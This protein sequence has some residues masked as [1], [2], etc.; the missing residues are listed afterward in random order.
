MLMR[1]RPLINRNL[2]RGIGFVA[3]MTLAAAAYLWPDSR[4]TT[5]NAL[6]AQRASVTG[7]EK[8]ED[9]FSVSGKA[10]PVASSGERS[11]SA[12][13]DYK[14]SFAESH[15]YWEYA[16]QILPAAK[17]GNADA[18][19]YLSRLL[20]RC[21][22]ENTMYFQHKG[23]IL[24]L[25]E[26]LQFAVQRH[27]SIETAQSVYE[28]CHAFQGSDLSELGNGSDWLRKATASGQPLAQAT[29]ASK[30]LTQEMQQDFAKAGGVL[31]PNAEEVFEGGLDPRDLLRK[32]VQSK[33]P[34]VLFSIGETQALLDPSNLDKNT[35]RFAWW[36]IACE[37]GFDCSADADWV[38]NTC[39]SDPQCAS[40]TGPTDLVRALS[41]DNWPS[42]QQRAQEISG[43]LDDGQWSE[44]GIGS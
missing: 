25:D 7:I 43:K 3:S 12:S 36:L 38:K 42:V 41:G 19:F 39:G 44:L 24:T 35:N 27:L 15:D 32:A 5:Q 21:A 22:E 17:A 9:K 1:V 14:K 31:N 2:L 4:A 11:R 18:Q 28:K 20:D 30:M 13:I 40:V 37:R 10:I 33:D 6:S 29:T 8:A 34:E 16:H 23:R 26:G